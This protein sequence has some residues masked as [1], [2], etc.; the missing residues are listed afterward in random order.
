MIE[1]LLLKKMMIAVYWG[2]A[3]ALVYIV[4]S[5]ALIFPPSGAYFTKKKTKTKTKRHQE[6]L[7]IPGK[8]MKNSENIQ[9]AEGRPA[10]AEILCHVTRDSI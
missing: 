2:N 3:R 6:A 1:A 8:I 5:L 4:R 7:Y 10:P 9:W